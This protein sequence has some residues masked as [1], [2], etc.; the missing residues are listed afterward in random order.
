[1]GRQD[2]VVQLTG[3]VGNLS[4]YKTQDGYL[5]RKKSRV[6]AKRI[7]TDPAFARTRENIAEFTRSGRAAKLLRTAFSSLLHS[8]ADNRV[9][10]RLNG[11]M[12]KVIQADLV[13]PRGR[14]NVV[15]GEAVLLEGFEFNQKGS[16]TNTFKAIF[17]PSIDRATGNMTV[18]IPAFRSAHE[19]QV[20]EGATHFRL[21]AGGAAI[22]FENNKYSL[23]TSEGAELPITEQT[24]E[25]L[26]LAHAV[27]ANSVFPL[28]LVFGIEFLQLVNGAYSPL[29]N[30]A[31][32]ALAIVK[33]D[34]G[35][36]N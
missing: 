18:D 23:A 16:L 35:V 12:M 19:I 25:A 17:T 14:R 10:S 36:T 1:M 8:A 11:A 30:G 29:N 28:F 26:Q 27:P 3:G 33:V 32:N 9:T 31:F 6:S 4:F 15:D 22:D 7:R 2:S 20:P 24:Q 34:G 13:N 5:A 21:K